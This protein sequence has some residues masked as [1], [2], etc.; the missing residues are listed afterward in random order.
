MNSIRLIVYV[1]ALSTVFSWKVTQAQSNTRHS[2]HYL[3]SIERQP[4]NTALVEFAKNTEL[5]VVAPSLLTANKISNPLY[6]YLA[7]INALNKMLLNTG[8]RAEID[9]NGIISVVVEK[10]AK[11]DNVYREGTL[12]DSRADSTAKNNIDEVVTRRQHQSYPAQ[13]A[14]KKNNYTIANLL[15]RD[16]LDEYPSL[17]LVESLTLVPGAAISRDSGEG[18][19]L[20]LRGLPAHF[21]NTQINGLD[22]LFTSDSA[23]DQR[24]GAARSRGFDFNLFPPN[25]F[26]AIVVSKSP[27]A[28]TSEGGVAGNVNL[29]T[30]NPLEYDINSASGDVSIVLKNNTLDSRLT[31]SFTMSGNRRWNTFALSANLQYSDINSVEH[32]VHNWRWS[33]SN[34]AKH[35]LENAINIGVYDRLVHA[36]DD[37]RVFIPEGNSIS[38]WGN[39]RQRLSAVAD[40]AWQLNPESSLLVKGLFGKLTNTRRHFQLATA[41]TN[42]LRPNV[43]GSQWLREAQIKQDSLVYAVFSNIDLRTEHQRQRSYTNYYQISS[44][45]TWRVSPRF[46]GAMT[47]GRSQ[48]TFEVPENEKIFLEATDKPLTID[49]RKPEDATFSYGFSVDDPNNWR[50]MRSD[51]RED[52]IANIHNIIKLDAAYHINEQVRLEIGSQLKHFTSSGWERRSSVNWLQE[53]KVPEVLFTLTDLPLQQ[54]YVVAQ[55]SATFASIEASGIQHRDLSDLDVRLGTD[56]H[57]DEN[58]QSSYAQLISSYHLL[59]RPFTSQIGLKY[60]KTKQTARGD[61]FEQA[62]SEVTREYDYWLPS[63]NVKFAIDDAWGLRAA[64]SKSVA[65]A[66]INELKPTADV[67]VADAFIQLGNPALRPVELTSADIYLNYVSSHGSFEVTMFNKSFRHFITE[68]S[69][70]TEYLNTGLPDALLN[71]D[72]RLTPQSE[73]T[74][75]SPING[76]TTTINGLEIAGAWSLPAPFNAFAVYGNASF[77]RGSTPIV[78]N[79]E[80]LNIQVPGLS[81]RVINATLEYASDAWRLQILASYRSSYVRQ[82]GQTQNTS[83]GFDDMLFWDFSADYDVSPVLSLNFTAKNLTDETLK[84]FQDTRPL[85][86]LRSGRQF[87]AGFKLHF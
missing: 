86:Y 37:N 77:N 24:G 49:W 36:K 66:N 18:R 67:N 42:G 34:F 12:A 16:V 50:L 74:V 62:N 56:Y 1:V 48:S 10:P 8:L 40:A 33:K 7:P 61:F 60:F 13:Q 9:S 72:I 44:E 68:R 43:D 47:L 69:F 17:N 22:I 6:G 11:A 29:L 21:V 26:D 81:K 65:R 45:F 31:P 46:S 32:G 20:F 3:F 59:D 71:A 73:F 87:L 2:N 39:A 30:S 14:F 53:T 38:A 85:I 54:P 35:T 25:M 19:Q 27:D 79:G 58:T 41:G 55:H 64:L 23:I 78:K 75:S 82:I 84:Q 57:L 80:R 63:L 76:E 5:T 70:T 51:V 83:E 28:K 15:T 52:K 4:L